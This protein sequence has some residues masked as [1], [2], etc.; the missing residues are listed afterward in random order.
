MTNRRANP[1]QWVP[2]GALAGDREISLI[3]SRAHDTVWI[4][5]ITPRA[6]ATQPFR[7]ARLVMYI[8]QE[9]FDDHSYV[10]RCRSVFLG[11]YSE[12]QS[13]SVSQI[14]AILAAI[15]SHSQVLPPFE[16]R[17]DDHGRITSEGLEL[18]TTRAAMRL[19]WLDRARIERRVYRGEWGL[20]GQ[21]DHFATAANLVVQSTG[22]PEAPHRP[23]ASGGHPQPPLQVPSRERIFYA[24]PAGGMPGESACG[25]RPRSVLG[26]QMDSASPL[27]TPISVARRPPAGAPEQ[28]RRDARPRTRS[29]RG[30]ARRSRRCGCTGRLKPRCERGIGRAPAQ[31]C[32]AAGERRDHTR[33]TSAR[34]HDAGAPHRL[35]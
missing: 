27:G 17:P 26:G 25:A 16:P 30:V 13:A 8:S 35:R 34:R 2:E 4:I 29:S 19:G 28:S 10:E 21:A 33:L 22:Q 31:R 23:C 14:L 20:R 1:Y 32:A 9:G 7:T 5:R 15:G 12:I 18:H 3:T 11:G 24:V 6:P